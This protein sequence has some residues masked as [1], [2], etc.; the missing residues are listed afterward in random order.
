M[1]DFYPMIYVKEE[2]PATLFKKNHQKRAMYPLKKKC[3]HFSAKSGKC[4]WRFRSN[5]HKK[6]TTVKAQNVY[7]RFIL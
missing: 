7:L 1:A 5:T 2:T 6:N 4:P 3:L